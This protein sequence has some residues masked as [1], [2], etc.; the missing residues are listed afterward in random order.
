MNVPFFGA[1]EAYFQTVFREGLV[2]QISSV[3]RYGCKR[4]WPISLQFCGE[5]RWP[6]LGWWVNTYVTSFKGWMWCWW[7][8]RFT[9]WY[10]KAIHCFNGCFNWM[11]FTK[12]LHGK[13]L[14]LTI[15]IHFKLVF[16][17]SRHDHLEELS[18]FV[19]KINQHHHMEYHPS[20][21]MKAVDA[22]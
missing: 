17:G 10:P 15:S 22:I 21:W 11:M 2:H 12:S 8:P 14:E 19:P 1:F 20:Q 16:G 7:P 13:W 3:S 4:R 18:E 5:K 9:T 6:F